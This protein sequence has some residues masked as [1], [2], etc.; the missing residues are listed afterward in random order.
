[1]ILDVLKAR[2]G[3]PQVLTCQDIGHEG[4]LDKTLPRNAGR[5]ITLGKEL[6]QL[7]V[8]AELSHWNLPGK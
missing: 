6:E 8:A 3:V 5:T 2:D 4:E 1:M 7:G